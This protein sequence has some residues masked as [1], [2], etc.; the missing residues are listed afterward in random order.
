MYSRTLEV[1]NFHKYVGNDI[2]SPSFPQIQTPSS[3]TA[4]QLFS[5]AYS[6]NI[7]NF[8]TAQRSLDRVAKQTRRLVHRGRQAEWGVE[9]GKPP[10]WLNWSS[11]PFL[12]LSLHGLGA[13]A[14]RDWNFTARS[15]Y[16]LSLISKHLFWCKFDFLKEPNDDTVMLQ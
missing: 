9:F 13:L 6:S 16:L 7:S 14:S 12:L 4:T 10:S 11:F 15:C 1:V 2:G 3:K 8:I 5:P